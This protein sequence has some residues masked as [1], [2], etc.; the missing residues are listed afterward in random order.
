MKTINFE[1]HSIPVL[2]QVKKV[3]YCGRYGNIVYLQMF[4]SSDETSG[5]ITEFNL[6]TRKRELKRIK[7]TYISSESVKKYGRTLVSEILPIVKN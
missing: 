6:Q 3:T 7:V 1:G 4:T 2:N 5:Y